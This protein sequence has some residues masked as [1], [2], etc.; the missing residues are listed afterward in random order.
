MNVPYLTRRYGGREP[1]RPGLAHPSIAPYGVFHLEGGDIVLAIQ[2]EREWGSFCAEVL[3]EPGL[4]ADPRF[5]SNLARVRNRAVLDAHVQ[6][7]LSQRPHDEAIAALERA[8]IAF[9]PVATVTDLVSHRSATFAP[10]ETP[11]GMVDLLA[12]PVILDG[13]RRALRRVARLGEQDAALR[14]EFLGVGASRG[15]AAS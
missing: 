10:V 12:P 1:P 3:G 9:G 13:Q 7:K 15:E 5:E 8:R 2:S 4:A 6:E 14:R 11:K